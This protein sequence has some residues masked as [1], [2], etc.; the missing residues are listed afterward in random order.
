M[1]IHETG[2]GRAVTIGIRRGNR[3]GCGMIYNFDINGAELK[4]K[5]RSWLDLNV[6]PVLQRGG[7]ISIE[8]IADRMGTDE[9]NMRLARLRA[10]ATLNYLRFRSPG[11]LR[12][13]SYNWTGELRAREAG[14]L[15]DTYDEYY[16]AVRI[17]W[18]PSSVPPPRPP[19]PDIGRVRNIERIVRREFSWNEFDS[20]FVRPSTSRRLPG[21]GWRRVL[22]E[23]AFRI[24]ELIGEKGIA[25]RHMPEGREVS[26]GRRLR[27]YPADCVVSRVIITQTTRTTLSDQVGAPGT[28]TTTRTVFEYEWDAHGDG[29][30]VVE[31][32]N[33]AEFE[34]DARHVE[35]KLYTI[36]LREARHNPYLVPRIH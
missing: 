11:R 25:P 24:A 13:R 34:D 1:S 36:P 15:D 33:I 5:H 18:S 3:G 16:R 19:E 29:I 14:V 17:C 27:S 21:G 30:V 6:V 28:L 12:S 10:N 26:G 2:P 4:P 22:A 35:R 23:G 8:G 32:Y 7:S 9:H 31:N 20:D